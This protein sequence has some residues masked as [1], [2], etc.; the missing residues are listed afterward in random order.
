MLKYILLAAASGL[1]LPLQALFNARTSSVLGGPLWATF[2][3]FAGGTI[4][5]IVLLAVI[6]MPPPTMDQIGRVPFYCWFS[7]LMGMFFV[8]Q[9][10]VTIPKLG[11]AAMIAL[12]IA[13]QMFGSIIYDHFGV[14][15]T[16]DPVSWQKILGALFLLAGVWLIL[17]P[18]H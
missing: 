4:M 13:G 8:G 16:A 2:V 5:M 3:N 14:L 11:A 6:R 17:R 15:Q 18:G 1:F 10:A 12:V 7:G 9:A